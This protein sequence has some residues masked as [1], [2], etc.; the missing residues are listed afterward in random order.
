[1]I[2]KNKIISDA[3][4]L[5]K[6]L[7]DDCEIPTTWQISKLILKKLLI[8]YMIQIVMC[9]IDVTMHKSIWEVSDTHN[10]VNASLISCGVV[11]ILWF[12]FFYSN[13]SLLLC[14]D[15]TVK[16]NSLIL[17]II[18]GKVRDYFYVTVA[19]VLV[20]AGCLLFYGPAWV[21]VLGIVWV[22]CTFVGCAVFSMSMSRYMTPAVVATLDKIRQAV[23]SG[24]TELAKPASD[25]QH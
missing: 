16:D 22:V 13:S 8:V 25:Q 10:L 24:D 17:R 11:S 5:L 12:V 19:I 21:G 15:D 3:D 14:V 23:S 20:S 6:C 18:K 1:M 7:V 9:G 2:T 4:N